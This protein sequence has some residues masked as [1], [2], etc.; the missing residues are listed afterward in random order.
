MESKERN[1]LI[2]SLTKLCNSDEGTRRKALKE[3]LEGFLKLSGEE[4]D[5]MV[6]ENLFASLE[7][8][9]ERY[10]KLVNTTINLMM[11]SDFSPEEQ[12][13]LLKTHIKAV[14]KLDEDKRVKEIA[15]LQIV[16]QGLEE[17]KKER[18]LKEAKESGIDLEK[19][20]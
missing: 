14:L 9:S 10:F 15:T 19:D 6:F 18:L 16:L 17:D 20:N 12:E 13:R 3:K 5:R 8:E 4:R 7:I 11:D 2:E 1:E